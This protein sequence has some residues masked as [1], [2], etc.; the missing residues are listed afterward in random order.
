MDIRLERGALALG[1]DSRVDFF[2]SLG[3]HFLDTSRWM[4]PS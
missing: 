3:D 4:R 2:L 1:L